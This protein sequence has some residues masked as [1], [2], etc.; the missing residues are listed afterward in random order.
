MIVD[1]GE[2]TGLGDLR[3]SGDS[4]FRCKGVVGDDDF[5][6][7]CFGGE[8]TDRALGEDGVVN[9]GE[10]ADEG[11]LMVAG[12]DAVALG[13]EDDV[14]ADDG[15]S[16]G[17]DAVIAGVPD[18]VT[19]DDIGRFSVGIVN[20]DAGVV[21]VVDDVVADDVVV[22]AVLEF[23]PVALTDGASLEI[24]DVVI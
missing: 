15:V 22:A 6:A 19:L 18:N 4:W 7:E 21:G 23:D 13:V 3:M 11:T 2:I 14:V 9:D 8:D 16:S 10:V 24:V 5:S 1:P 17:L 20:D 12:V